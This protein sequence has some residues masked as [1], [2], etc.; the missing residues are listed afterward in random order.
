[1]TSTSANN[2]EDSETKLSV[3]TTNEEDGD[4]IL[5]LSTE[6]YS[7]TERDIYFFDAVNNLSHESA[8]S[9]DDIGMINIPSIFYGS[10]IKKGT[11][12]L[13]YYITGSLIATAKD[14]NH[15]G[16]LICTFAENSAP[17]SGSVIGHVL[18][19]EGILFFP[20]SSSPALASGN[21]VTY[22]GAVDHE[23]WIHFGHGANEK[24][25]LGALV[26]PHVSH[27]KASYSIN[28]E[29]MSTDMNGT[30]L[31]SE[32]VLGIAKGMNIYSDR[33][34]LIESGV[35]FNLYNY[36]KDFVFNYCII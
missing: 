12:Q 36:E 13:N 4:S 29:N 5:D 16:Q 11:I 7:F 8:D 34:S 1:M 6:T 15:N 9:S 33:Q 3:S 18:Y 27:K 30:N 32:S 28:F 21:N 35:R 25:D 20:K 10:E 19:R 2:L 22:N 17:A 14:E 23:K 24:N 26:T 31:L